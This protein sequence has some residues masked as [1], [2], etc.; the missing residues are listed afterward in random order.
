VTVVYPSG[1]IFDQDDE[2]TAKITVTCQ[3]SLN[4]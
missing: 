4:D 1:G 2:F 3:T